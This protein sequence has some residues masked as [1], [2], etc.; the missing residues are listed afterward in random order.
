MNSSSVP[1][2]RLFIHTLSP[3]DCNMA[4]LV[5][6][7]NSIFG[8]DLLGQINSKLIKVLIIS[9]GEGLGK[10]NLPHLN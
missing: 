3:D 5:L 1:L 8:A 9:F 6:T 2:A 7:F 10:Q 4:C